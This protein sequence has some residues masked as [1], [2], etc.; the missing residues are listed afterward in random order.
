MNS[1]NPF[2]VEGSLYLFGEI[3]PQYQDLLITFQANLA[4]CIETTGNLSFDQWRSFRSQLRE[5]EGPFRFL[6]GEMLERFLDLTESTQEIVCE[7]LGPSVEEMRNIV[8][9][10]RRLH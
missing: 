5:S 2:Q 1:D 3:T 10:L 8:E 7:G 9:E 6:D 4:R